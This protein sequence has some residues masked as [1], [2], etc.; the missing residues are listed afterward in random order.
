M[1]NPGSRHDLDD[2]DDDRDDR[3]SE[4]EGG[5]EGEKKE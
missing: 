2:D 4:N 1:M 3:G 5:R